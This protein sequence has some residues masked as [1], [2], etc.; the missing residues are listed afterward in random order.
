[1]MNVDIFSI[2]INL[3]NGPILT[4]VLGKIRGLKRIYIGHNKVSV[5]ILGKVCGSK[6]TCIAHYR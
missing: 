3:P 6:G 5:L 1:M 4:K 2:K